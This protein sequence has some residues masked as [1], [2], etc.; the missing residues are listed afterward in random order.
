MVHMRG[1]KIPRLRSNDL[2]LTKTKRIFF[3][4][5]LTSFRFIDLAFLVQVTPLI[6]TKLS[7]CFIVLW[8]IYL[9]QLFFKEEI[10]TFHKPLI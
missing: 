10:A 6:N 1:K 3:L 5:T 2:R 7:T 4:T 8:Q 9:E